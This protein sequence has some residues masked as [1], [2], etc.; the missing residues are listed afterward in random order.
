MTIAVP[1]APHK[2]VGAQLLQNLD[3]HFQKM[4]LYDLSEN[5]TFTCLYENIRFH[6]LEI[7][8]RLIINTCYVLRLIFW[9]NL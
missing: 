5:T 8:P 1:S 9:V 6:V 2:S 7:F 3:A 4:A